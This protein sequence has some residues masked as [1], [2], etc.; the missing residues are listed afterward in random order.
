MC[1]PLEAPALA[2]MLPLLLVVIVCAATTWTASS[3]HQVG[4]LPPLDQDTVNALV[5]NIEAPYVDHCLQILNGHAFSFSQAWQDWVLFNHHFRN[6]TTWGDGFYIDI[7]SAEPLKIS[8]TL[9]FDKCLGWKG[10]CIEPQERYHSDIKRT[11]GCTL[12]PHCVLYEAAQ[13]TLTG[14]EGFVNVKPAA[15][16]GTACLGIREMLDA[17]DLTSRHID[18]LSI[19]IEGAESSVFK[20]WDFRSVAPTAVLMET[21]KQKLTDVDWFFHRHGYSNVETFVC[22]G[23]NWLDNLYIKKEVVYPYPDFS[24][25]SCSAEHLRF[26]AWCAPWN[27]HPSHSTNWMCDTPAAPVNMGQRRCPS[28]TDAIRHAV[29]SVKKQ[30]DSRPVFTIKRWQGRLGNHFIAVHNAVS[31]AVCC[32]GVVVLPV[33]SKFPRL[34]THVD[35]S[36]V[37]P[38]AEASVLSPG[39]NSSVFEDKDGVGRIYAYASHMPR[40][41]LDAM[42][43]CSYDDHAIMLSMF[44]DE[45][46]NC[47][48]ACEKFNTDRLTVH[49]RNGDIFRSGQAN[50]DYF[51]YPVA[52]YTA[53]ISQRTWGEVF[54]VSDSCEEESCNPVLFWFKNISNTASRWPRTTFTF[55]SGGDLRQALPW[56][57]VA[58]PISSAVAAL[59]SRRAVPRHDIIAQRC[60]APLSRPRRQ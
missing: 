15:S 29:S 34:P 50:G 55:S 7:G 30:E 35:L 1:R 47:A 56:V 54:F 4:H 41:M 8:N 38:A 52:M 28:A 12:I 2:P 24:D 43:S 37:L 39:C 5:K 9:F 33:N 19:D 48:S 36:S 27:Q 23:G 60:A 25:F 59:G 53:V 42:N 6:K 10:L 46:P 11:R 20:C 16:G 40:V 51:Q 31:L 26:N 21:N 57:V 3:L 58:A 14:E 13:V 49:I 44:L 17:H 45:T 22:C 32:R 18:V